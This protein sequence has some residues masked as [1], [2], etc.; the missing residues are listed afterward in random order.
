M[1][2]LYLF[3]TILLQCVIISVFWV[4]QQFGLI[5]FLYLLLLIIGIMLYKDTK[6]D[7]IAKDLGWG[8]MF[9]S[10]G[11]LVIMFSFFIWL[12]FNLVQ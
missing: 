2:L 8:I 1:K 4:T 9:G 6:S 10:I 11:L 12:S 3:L 5:I 7:R